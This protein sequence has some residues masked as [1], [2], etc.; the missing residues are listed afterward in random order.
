MDY[1]ILFFLIAVLIFIQ[2]FWKYDNSIE[3]FYDS[4]IQIDNLPEKILCGER[5]ISSDCIKDLSEYKCK[6]R[7]GNL[8]ICSNGI[9]FRCVDYLKTLEQSKCVDTLT[10]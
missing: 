6:E 5:V 8:Q 2:I 3:L 9:G 1:K 7:Q 10:N 4:C